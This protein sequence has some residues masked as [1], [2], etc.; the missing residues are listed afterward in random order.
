[1]VMCIALGGVGGSNSEGVSYSSHKSACQDL[2]TSLQELGAEEDANMYVLVGTFFFCRNN[3]GPEFGSFLQSHQLHPKFKG[4]ITSV[5]YVDLTHT[6]NPSSTDGGTGRIVPTTLP[7]LVGRKVVVVGPSHLK[8]LRKTLNFASF[9]DATNAADHVP[10]IVD[11]I[12]DESAKWP[13]ENV[14]FL[15]SGGFGGRLAILKAFKD[16]GQ[17]DSLIDTG[18]SLDGFAGVESRGLQQP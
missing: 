12:K 3:V 15:V 7:A 18:A 6:G 8:V 1:M 13:Q 4:F 16:V 2:A 14:I 11:A 10:Q 17:K 9:I 5:F